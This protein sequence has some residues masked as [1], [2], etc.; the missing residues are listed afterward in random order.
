MRSAID[1]RRFKPAE[2]PAITGM[3][4]GYWRK[5]ILH[6]C[7]EVERYGRSVRIRESA[8]AKFL[9]DQKEG[10]GRDNTN[11]IRS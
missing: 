5:Q 6:Q 1:E 9:D 2:L 10:R 11:L 3:S 7:I 8:L 4:L